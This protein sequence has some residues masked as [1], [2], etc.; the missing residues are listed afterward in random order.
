M[1]VTCPVHFILL[2]LI[3]LIKFGEVYKCTM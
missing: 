1:R 3:I 2:N